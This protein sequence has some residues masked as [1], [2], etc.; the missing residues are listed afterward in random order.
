MPSAIVT[1]T[2]WRT[3]GC[4]PNHSS[5]R[6]HALAAFSMKTGTPRAEVSNDRRSTSGQPRFGAKSATRRRRPGLGSSRR[7]HRSG[8]AG[9]ALGAIPPPWP[10]GPRRPRAYRRLPL[11]LKREPRIEVGETNGR[12]VGTQLDGDRGDAFGVDAQEP[13]PAAARQDS[14]LALIDPP[15]ADQLFDD[16]GYGAALEARSTRHVSAGQGLVAA[17]Q[18][19]SDAPV[20]PAG[21]FAGR[22]SEVRKVDLRMGLRE[23]SAGSHECLGGRARGPR[24]EADRWPAA[25]RQRCARVRLRRLLGSP[26]AVTRRKVGWR[27]PSSPHGE[28]KPSRPGNSPRFG[29]VP[30]RRGRPDPAHSMCYAGFIGGAIPWPSSRL[31]RS[32]NPADSGGR[33]W[34]RW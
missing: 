19:E 23:S 18:A 25:E 1:A 16:R 7:R 4:S 24:H 32:R 15:L 22:D 12:D 20:D 13:R 8:V 21:R 34:S 3:S 33:R 31:Q 10:G 26:T 17:D 28:Q 5:A 14:Q 29:N 30:S 27:R 6:A 2:R 9:A 11:L